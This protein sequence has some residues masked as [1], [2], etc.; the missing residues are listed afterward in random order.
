M[1]VLTA[2][3]RLPDEVVSEPRNAKPA[4]LPRGT[5]TSPRQNKSYNR[6]ICERHERKRGQRRS[7]SSIRPHPL[8]RILRLS[9]LSFPR[10]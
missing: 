5:D 1:G 4:I 9:R 7:S 2:A 8:S 3:P 6:E 10:F